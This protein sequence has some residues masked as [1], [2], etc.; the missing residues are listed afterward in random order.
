MITNC[1]LASTEERSADAPYEGAALLKRTDFIVKQT[2]A[3]SQ[4]KQNGQ[5]RVLDIGCGTGGITLSLGAQ[6]H[7]V[8]GVD[9][10][11]GSISFCNRRNS[12]PNVSFQVWD[13][14][15]PDLHQKFDVVIASEV[16]E[17]TEHPEMLVQAIDRHLKEDGTGILSV[18]NGYC[19]WELIVSRFIQKSRLVSLLYRSPRAHKILTGGDTPFYSMNVFCFHSHFFSFGRLKRLLADAGFKIS[20]VRHSDLGIAPEWFL[21]RGLKRIECKIAD[22]APHNLAGGWLLVIRRENHGNSD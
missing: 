2:L 15:K 14:D 21:F 7:T 4:R 20:L 11:P 6:G 10:D 9:V 18:P 3:C 12:L 8:V 22:F 17:H 16:L 1:N 13:K 5:L 19:L